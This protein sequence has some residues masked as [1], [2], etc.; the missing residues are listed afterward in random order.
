MTSQTSDLAAV[1]ARL[2]KVERDLRV[3]KRRT[4]W[5]MVGVGLATVGL[6]LGW[7]MA[8]S[9]ATA[10]TQAPKVIR[11][12]YFILED[13]NGKSRAELTVIAGGPTL[14]LSD[15]RGND[16]AALSVSRGGPRVSLLDENGKS[17]RTQP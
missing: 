5:L 15:E 2:E 14:V 12:N 1:V 16:P 17:I 6:V 11:A 10:Q 7:T 8:N 4:R 3:A 9:T 13:E